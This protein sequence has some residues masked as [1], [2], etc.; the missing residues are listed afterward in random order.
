MI[1]NATGIPNVQAK[2]NDPFSGASLL[3]NLKQTTSQ[4]QKSSQAPPNIGEGGEMKDM[5]SM[6]EKLSKQL[7]NMEDDGDDDL[8]DD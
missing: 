7:E 3:N 2:I 5:M 4:E 1:N 6:F 8:T